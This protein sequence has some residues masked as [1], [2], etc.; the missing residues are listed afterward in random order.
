MNGGEK[1]I[2]NLIQDFEK[3]SELKKE[4]KSYFVGAVVLVSD[5]N[6]SY[7]PELIDGQ[8]RVTTVFL[9][10]YI[11]YL[12]LISEIDVLLEQKKVLS[13]QKEMERMEQCYKWLV[14]TKK[15]KEFQE[16]VSNL[17]TELMKWLSKRDDNIIDGYRK[18]Y[19]KIVGLPMDKDLANIDLYMTEWKKARS[20]A[21]KNEEFAIEYSRKSLNDKLA[22][23]LKNVAIVFSSSY[24]PKFETS[25]SGEDDIVKQYINAMSL[26]FAALKKTKKYNMPKSR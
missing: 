22:E 11:K 13:I 8:Q 15:V 23:A 16:L 14:G 6:R 12:L 9:L 17:E 26:I 7:V 10:N 5:P 1:Q 2:T 19:K 21:M 24:A 20:G 18:N 25:Y 4:D 3:N